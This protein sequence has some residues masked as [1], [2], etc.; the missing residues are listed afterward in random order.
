M[1]IEGRNTVGRRD[2][3]DILDVSWESG[4]YQWKVQRVDKQPLLLVGNSP[5][6]TVEEVVVSHSCTEAVFPFSRQSLILI[7]HKVQFI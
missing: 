6:K 3:Y 2:R 4:V 1:V 5:Q 7:T